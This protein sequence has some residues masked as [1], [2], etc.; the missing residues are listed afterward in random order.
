[1]EQVPPTVTLPFERRELRGSSLVGGSSI[2]FSSPSPPISISSGFPLPGLLFCTAG[3]T[4]GAAE[5]ASFPFGRPAFGLSSSESTSFLAR[6]ASF[7]FCSDTR[8]WASRLVLLTI[9]V[10]AFAG[11]VA[12]VVREINLKQ[13]RSNGRSLTVTPCVMMVE[14]LSV[15]A[16]S[17]A[18]WQANLGRARPQTHR[19]GPLDVAPA[20]VRE[21]HFDQARFQRA[22][23]LQQ[24]VL[25]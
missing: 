5:T 8:P 13:V 16:E 23:L 24:G 17:A 12:G 1:M 14:N 11:S 15:A 19:R 10:V 3:A 7:R 25:V 21:H 2:I 22:S 20:Q 9:P 6:R 4:A 18:D